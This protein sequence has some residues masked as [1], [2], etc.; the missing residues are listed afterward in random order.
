MGRRCRTTGDDFDGSRRKNKKKERKSNNPLVPE[1]GRR[2]KRGRKPKNWV[3]EDDESEKKSIKSDEGLDSEDDW[4]VGEEDYEVAKAKRRISRK[5]S[6][7]RRAWA[8]D[9]DTAAAAGRTWPV[10]PKNMVP[11]VLGTMLEEVIKNDNA[12]GGLF[13]V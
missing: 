11:K 9:K 2:K 8:C 7:R 3:P 1:Q 4:S 6:R 10:I 5:E 12:K 13:S